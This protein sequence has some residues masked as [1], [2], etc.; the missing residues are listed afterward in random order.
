MR[1]HRHHR[2]DDHHEHGPA[3]PGRREAL[4]AGA[5]V[6]AASLLASVPGAMP[7]ERRHQ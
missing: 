4:Q 5:G 6:V 2:R 7:D 3:L 1:E